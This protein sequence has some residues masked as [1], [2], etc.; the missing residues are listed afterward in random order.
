MS[1]YLTCSSNSSGGSGLSDYYEYVPLV[2]ESSMMKLCLS[3]T[4]ILLNRRYFL[5]KVM[6]LHDDNN[7]GENRKFCFKRNSQPLQPLQ[8][9]CSFE[10]LLCS[11]FVTIYITAQQTLK[12]DTK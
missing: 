12:S 8:D 2:V 7:S 9:C 1:D 4:H 11:F 10:I 3:A 5:C 6:P